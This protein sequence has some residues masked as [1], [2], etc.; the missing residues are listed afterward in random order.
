ME[1]IAAADRDLG[2]KAGEWPAHFDPTGTANRHNAA[3]R[4]SEVHSLYL[5]DSYRELHDYLA[6]SAIV[7]ILCALRP[8][9]ASDAL[10]RRAIRIPHVTPTNTEG[11]RQ[12]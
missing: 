9:T 8:L 11:G 5:G 7:D 12:V 6:S 1:L 10:S 3:R 4:A 2:F